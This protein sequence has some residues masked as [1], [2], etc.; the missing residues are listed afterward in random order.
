MKYVNITLF[1]SSFILALIGS[2]YIGWWFV[3]YCL[4]TIPTFT[5][6]SP[7]GSKIKHRVMTDKFMWRANHDIMFAVGLFSFISQVITA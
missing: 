6:S 2:F 5:I 1:L 7:N 4:I 3:L